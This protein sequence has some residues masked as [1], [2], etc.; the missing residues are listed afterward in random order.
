MARNNKVCY[1]ALFYV[2]KRHYVIVYRIINN[3]TIRILRVLSTCQD[4]CSK[5]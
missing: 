2:V 4:I 3:N 5:L 1:K